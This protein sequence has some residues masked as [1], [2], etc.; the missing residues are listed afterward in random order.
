[1]AKRSPRTETEGA[2]SAALLGQL[3]AALGRISELEDIPAAVNDAFRESP[4]DGLTISIQFESGQEEAGSPGGHYSPARSFELP[5]VYGGET[6]GMLALEGSQLK[7]TRPQLGFLTATAHLIAASVAAKRFVKEH[8]KTLEK[9]TRLAELG[10]LVNESLDLSRILRVVRDAV[11]EDGNFDR[12]GVFLY[13]KARKELQGTWGTDRLGRLESIYHRVIPLADGVHGPDFMQPDYLGPGFLITDDFEHATRQISETMQ[14]VHRHAIVLLRANR[15]TLGYIAVDNLITGRLFDEE[16]LKL[17]LPF[18]NQAAGAIYKA[19]VLEHSERIADQ[20]RRLAELAALMNETMD[21]SRVMRLVRDAAISVGGFDRSGVFLYDRARNVVRGSWG[22][23]REGHIEDNHHLVFQ[24]TEQNS[25]DWGVTDSPPPL[26]YVKADEEYRAKHYDKSDQMDGVE[27]NATIYL[28]ANGQ[29]VGVICVDNAITNRPIRDDDLIQLRPFAHQAAAAILKAYLLEERD[30][31]VRQQRRLLEV[32][33]AISDQQELDSIF[34]MVCQALK[35]T[36]W[37]DRVSLWL[38]DGEKLHGTI[39]IDESGGVVVRPADDLEIKDSSPSTLEVILEGKPFSI[40]ALNDSEEDARR[41][42][43]AVLGLRAGNQLLGVISCDTSS[44]FRP[45]LA[46]D[47]ETILPF[48]DQ[49]AVAILNA[50]LMK[51]AQ[52]ELVLRRRAESELQRYAEELLLARDQAVEA[53]RVKSEFLAN[54]SHEIRTPMNGVIGMTSILL[55]T[56]LSPTQYEYMR[57]VQRSAE[58]LMGVL[59]DVLDF[60]KIEA[61]KMLIDRV[62]FDLRACLEEVAEMM[63]AR[64]GEKDVHLNCRI[65]PAFPGLFMG[66]AGRVRQILTNLV[67]NSVKFTEAGEIT[68]EALELDK[69]HIRLAVRDTGIGIPAER[70]ESIFECFTQ[71]DGSMSRRYGGTGLGL[72]LTKQL[73]GLMGGTIGLISVEGEGSTFWVDLPLRRLSGAAESP[74]PVLAGKSILIVESNHGTARSLAEQLSYWGSKVELC[75]ER[76]EAEEI[77]GRSDSPVDVVFADPTLFEPS[78]G[79]P[80]AIA[81]MRLGSSGS[82]SERFTDR[83]NKPITCRQLQAVLS[84]VLGQVEAPLKPSVAPS[85]SSG[86]GLRV[87]VA[88]DTD[89]NRLIMEKYL[90]VLGCECTCVG[91]GARVMDELNRSNFDVVLMDLQMPVMDGFETTQRVRELGNSIPIIALT[92]H[93]QH[94]DRERCLAAGMDDYLSKPVR[95]A[96]LEAKLREWMPTVSRAA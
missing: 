55:E 82:I 79:G 92:A 50:S 69:S 56:P 14:G 95:R 72:T 64:I 59:N 18:A 57:T 12:A 26:G 34:R 7:L 90:S 70:Q 21:L 78:G 11:V 1:M 76:E 73:A 8:R 17:L 52:E 88:E 75:T 65:P 28:R 60:S 89:V 58:A 5:L 2:W 80:I 85:H 31:I 86:L 43:H 9:Q 68:V 10:S 25:A 19:R 94:G 6:V 51:A 37:M 44:S 23:D 47:V 96:E 54:M 45:I 49:V 42:P 13:D 29:P 53:T 15:E 36:G 87:L 61:G 33:A 62:E 91:D 4:F 67:G 20:Q 16:A 40:N 48:A 71:A 74:R 30:R 66:D 41:S 39:G 24:L 81:L 38:Y 84:G 3:A 22:T 77:L 35:E 63:A 32:S 46:Q 27:E 93:A 83:L